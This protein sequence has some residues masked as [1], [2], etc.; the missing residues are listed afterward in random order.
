M[1]ISGKRIIVIGELNV[2]VVATGLGQMPRLGQEILASDCQLTLGSASAIF[3]CG[4]AKLGNEV[5]FVSRVGR[6]EF[7]DFCLQE[8][9]RSGVSTK[10]IARDRSFRTGVTVSLSTTRDRAL[11]TYPGSIAAVEP[12][13]VS[14]SLLAKHDHLHMTSYF[15]QTG[16]QCSFGQIFREAKA[17]GLTTSFDP[18]SDPSQTWKANLKEVLAHTDILFVNRD[19]ASSLTRKR[20]RESALKVL[21][22][23][24]SLA[25]IKLGSQGAIAIQGNQI[26]SAPAFKVEVKDTTGAGDSFASG[27]VSS[28]LSGRSLAENLRRA[29]AC[30]ALSAQQVGGIAGQPTLRLLNSFLK[31]TAEEGH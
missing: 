1:R 6:D 23:L 20:R 3:A 13:M 28:Y 27:F 5:T 16:L 4:A 30:G 22:E 29:N 24:V 7:G 11:V 31:R 15:L 8:L 2:D 19:E 21:A 10:H 25:V 9:H 14:S 12:N 17:H 18:N 26:K